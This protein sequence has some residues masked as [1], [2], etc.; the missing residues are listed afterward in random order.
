MTTYYEMECAA[1]RGE[2]QELLSMYETAEK[3]MQKT[4]KKACIG[5]LIMSRSDINRIII[6]LRR[7]ISE[8]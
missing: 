8:N 1:R 2:L 3:N 6:H 4:A 7:K 5:G